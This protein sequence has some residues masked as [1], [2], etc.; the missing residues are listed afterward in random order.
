MWIVQEV[1]L[2]PIVMLLYS[3]H[4]FPSGTV[5]AIGSFA[6]Y[7]DSSTRE[8]FTPPRV[9]ELWAD[10]RWFKAQEGMRLACALKWINGE[11]SNVRDKVFAVLGTVKTDE[12]ALLQVNY[13]MPTEELFADVVR[14]MIVTSIDHFNSWDRILIWL[15]KYLGILSTLAP[16]GRETS[17]GSNNRNF[18]YINFMAM[19]I[20]R[21]EIKIDLRNLSLVELIQFIYEHTKIDYSMVVRGSGQKASQGV[22]GDAG[23]SRC[24]GT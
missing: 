5:H 11:C 12:R 14:A 6:Y 16:L 18:T 2:S 10:R 19:G 1:L 17:H 24:R 13:A 20:K 23:E 9:Y 8:T 3:P 7:R 15:A 4:I 21:S 22:V